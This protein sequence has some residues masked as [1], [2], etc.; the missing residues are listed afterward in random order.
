MGLVGCMHGEAGGSRLQRTSWLVSSGQL[1][2]V[3]MRAAGADGTSPA[4]R[5]FSSVFPAVFTARPIVHSVAS[6]EYASF[7]FG[8]ASVSMPHTPPNP[9]PVALAPP[10]FLWLTR[11]APTPAQIKNTLTTH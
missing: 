5:S 11:R 3:R 9:A 10:P 1:S 8:I 7:C 2:S 4:L 6:R